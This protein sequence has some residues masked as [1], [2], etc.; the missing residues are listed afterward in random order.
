[1]G[2]LAAL[3]TGYLASKGLDWAFSKIGDLVIR[4]C[5]EKRAAAFLKTFLDAIQRGEKNRCISEILDRYLSKDEY[6]ETIFSAYKRV[7]FSE[8]EET[9]PK[10]I[11]LV[12]ARNLRG[13]PKDADQGV[14]KI[15]ETLTDV[16]FSAFYEFSVE[17]IHQVELDANCSEIRVD[18]AEAKRENAISGY[19]N[20]EDFIGSWAVKLDQL[21]YVN[22]WST[23]EVDELIPRWRGEDDSGVRQGDVTF[24]IRSFFTLF[25]PAIETLKLLKTLKAGGVV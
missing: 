10:I 18:W 17:H 24:T 2:D 20:L 6:R 13:E 22:F 15:A 12:T 1:M 19:V 25:A 14:C 3:G 7:V 5:S 9:G 8:T 23:N 4:R 16:D 21:K 11:A